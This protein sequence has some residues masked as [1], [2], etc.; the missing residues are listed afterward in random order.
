MNYIEVRN[1]IKEKEK[2]GSSFGTDSV[3]ELLRRLDN[4]EKCAPAIHIAGTN[5]KGSIMAYVEETFVRTG[6]MVGRYISPTIYDYRER[7]LKNKEWAS[8]EDVAWAISIVAEATDGM[9]DE[10]LNSPTAFEIETAAA[11]VLFKKWKCDIM[12]IECGMGGRLDATN[13]LETDKLSVL[14]AISMDHMEVLGN[15][16]REIAKEKLG[17]VRDKSVLVT[18]PQI[19]PVMMEI[20]SYCKEHNVKLIEADVADLIINEESFYGSS[21]TYKGEDYEI[22]IGGRYQIYNA[23]TAIEILKYFKDVCEEEIYSGLLTTRWE[24][25]F[26][27]VSSDPVTIIDGAHNEDAW[28]RLSNSLDKYFTNKKIV[29]II[30]VLADKEYEKMVDILGPSMEYVYA[31]QSDSPRAL[32]AKDLCKVF[33]DAGIKS[34]ACDTYDK[35]ID[36]ELSSF[37]ENEVRVIYSIKKAQ[38]M[39]KEKGLPLVIAG[40]LS[41]TGQAIRYFKSNM[42][43]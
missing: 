38:E 10:G 19:P 40:T 34:E 35:D 9:V 27:L 7:W 28:L 12:L 21:F 24:G 43:I 30:G 17:I 32:P 25:R 22:S 36:C 11:F 23:I 29:Y 26:T 13:V 1:Y 3:K 37:S 41:I 20:Y 42:D 6:M 39:A 14:A 2:L 18:Y 15:S 16:P 31:V 5:G 33:L 8:E 4:P